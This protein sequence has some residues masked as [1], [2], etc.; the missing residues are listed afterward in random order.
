MENEVQPSI[1][2]VQPIPQTPP[3]VPSSTNWSKTLLFTVLGLII[4]VGS[5]FIGIQIG[6]NQTPSQQPIVTQPTTSPTQIFVDSTSNWKTYTGKEMPIQFKYPLNFRV[7]EGYIKGTGI[8]DDGISIDLDQTG[9]SPNRWIYITRS[10]KG[11]IWTSSLLTK[12]S[13][14]SIGSIAIPDD[15]S[16]SPKEWNTWVRLPDQIIDN[17]NWLVFENARP[18]ESPPPLKIYILNYQNNYYVIQ[19]TYSNLTDSTTPEESNFIDTVNQIFSTFR[20]VN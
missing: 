16:N 1:P 7:S 9:G 18:W 13:K 6:K 17:N 19:T 12:F 14:I 4:V 2:P 11:S 3:I 10:D 8:V 15:T 5:I 20:F